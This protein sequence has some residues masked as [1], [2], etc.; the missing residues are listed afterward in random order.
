M[1]VMYELKKNAKILSKQ[2]IFFIKL[3]DPISD[4]MNAC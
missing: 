1:E 3:F 4:T 2:V